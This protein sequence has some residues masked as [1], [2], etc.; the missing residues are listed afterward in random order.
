MHQKYCK[1]RPFE[2]ARMLHPFFGKKEM[3]SSDPSRRCHQCSSV[4]DPTTTSTIMN[5]ETVDFG[6]SSEELDRCP[7]SI[8]AF[9]AVGASYESPL[10]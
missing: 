9:P 10:I 8:L 5:L 3:N 6:P 4:P 2:P 1:L 7:Y